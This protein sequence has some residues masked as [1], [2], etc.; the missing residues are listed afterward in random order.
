MSKLTKRV[1]DATMAD[2]AKPVF[3][4]DDEL[5]GFGLKVLPSGA[6]RYVV[7]YRAGGGGRQAPQRWLTLGA[8]GTLTCE[9]ARGQARQALAA[10]ARG[11]DPQSE[12]MAKRKAP[13]TADLWERYKSDQLPLKKASTARDYRQRWKDV[14]EP[15]FG[16]MFVNEV[17]RMDVDRLHKRMRAKPYQANR[18][19]AQLSR[20]FNLAEAWGWREPGTNP[21]RHVEKFKEHAR[22]RYLSA[23]ELIGLG[24]ALETFAK[25]GRVSKEAVAAIRLL[26][27]TGARL[28]EILT[29]RRDWVDLERQVINLPDSKTGKKPVFLSE[30]AIEVIRQLD[31]E[32]ED[33]KNPYL[34]P[35]RSKGKPLNNLSKPWR[36]ICE[37]AGLEGVRLHDLRHT[38]ASIAVGQG[39]TL[40]LIGRL[41]GHR[42][43]QTT[44]RYAH[45]DADPALAVANDIGATIGPALGIRQREPNEPEND[46]KTS[47]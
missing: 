16:R 46:V 22:E 3:V 40:P 44:N 35:G 21:C 2:A 37:A 29:A 9:E 32:R 31:V 10:A 26:L 45:V 43:A 14:I 4:W 27:L 33:T 20:L 13:T 19:L 11:E 15:A 1:V 36:R 47:N 30:P 38:A 39:A 23:E 8:H 24:K 6:K 25:E 28:N 17:N 5:H 41:L 12:K 7:K 34:L 42:Q 18:V